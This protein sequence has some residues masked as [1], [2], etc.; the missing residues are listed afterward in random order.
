MIKP[1]VC[2]ICGTAVV[3]PEKE[4]PGWNSGHLFERKLK[5]NQTKISY[6]EL[7]RVRC[8]THKEKDD[9]RHYDSKGFIVESYGEFN[10]F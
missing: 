3:Q 1:G 2:G 7:V 5:D 9:P 6:L 10:C 8:M 4:D